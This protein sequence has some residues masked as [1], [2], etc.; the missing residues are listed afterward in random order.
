MSPIPKRNRK[1][2]NASDPSHSPVSF[3]S[4]YQSNRSSI[5]SVRKGI[6]K[7][8]NSCTTINMEMANMSR[9]DSP[10]ENGFAYKSTESINDTHSNGDTTR[11][12][13]LVLLVNDCKVISFS[14]SLYSYQKRL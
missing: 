11:F 9:P 6:L 13:R 14:Y 12:A 7:K 10:T 2:N 8:T 3:R 1:K 4:G 5:S